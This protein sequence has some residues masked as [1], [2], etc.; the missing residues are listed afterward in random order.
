MRSGRSG[1]YARSPHRP[2]FVA[3]SPHTNDRARG[4]PPHQ[5][6]SSL[7]NAR[8]ISLSRASKLRASSRCGRHAA[9][10]A[11]LRDGLAILGQGRLAVER[12][13]APAL[14]RGKATHSW[15]SAVRN[16]FI[17]A[18]RRSR[19]SLFCCS[20]SAVICLVA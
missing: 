10:G 7:E 6:S 16:S 4:R 8:P 11:G 5:R 9:R 3:T 18:R 14:P 13:I 12:G 19:S 15:A 1:A 2:P 20:S 17:R